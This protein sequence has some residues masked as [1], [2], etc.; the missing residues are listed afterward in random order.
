[1][2]KFMLYM[3]KLLKNNRADRERSENENEKK[4][5]N[6]I[7]TNITEGEINYQE[8]C[9]ELLNQGLV[10]FEFQGEL[11]T[12]YEDIKGKY[13]GKLQLN[14]KGI[15]IVEIGRWFIEG[16]I[17]ELEK[18]IMV[19]KRSPT[20]SNGNNENA[21]LKNHNYL[22]SL[23][24]DKVLSNSKIGYDV[25]KVFRKILLFKNRPVPLREGCEL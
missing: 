23:N 12:E 18:P 22:F 8:E 9:K 11:G 19:V 1:M 14:D 16:K 24:H 10:M 17:I 13:I 2:V 7:N 25:V 6:N 20:L 15:P 4:G 21:S 3:D 5:E